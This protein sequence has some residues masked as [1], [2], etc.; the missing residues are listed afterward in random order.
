[1][2]SNYHK[3]YQDIIN[4]SGSNEERYNELKSY[5]HKKGY[6]DREQELKFVSGFF[7]E[8]FNIQNDIFEI[9]WQQ[10]QDYN[11]NW[12]Y[13]D[14]Q[15]L[16]LNQYLYVNFSGFDF[17]DSDIW[18]YEYDR[19]VTHTEKVDDW[20]KFDQSIQEE[21]KHLRQHT[22]NILIF[23]RA[24]YDYYGR[25]YFIYLFG[26]RAKVKITKEGILID[27]ENVEL[28]GGKANDEAFMY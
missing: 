2:S 24:L 20:S 5:L 9:Q 16:K 8:L 7:S 17:A 23:L 1:M 13:F 19:S 10:Y 18:E 3:R 14:I 26:R 27:N 12:L 6:G 4:G 28:A 21:H 15:E 22:D 11:D 25:Y